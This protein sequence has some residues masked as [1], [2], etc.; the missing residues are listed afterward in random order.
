MTRLRTTVAS[1][2]VLPLALAGCGDDPQPKM[3]PPSASSP[4]TP[5]PSTST[6][7]AVE[8]TLP[9]EAEGK[10]EAAAE[11]FV[12]YYW[13]LANY[14]QSTGDAQTFSEVAL[15]SCTTCSRAASY[16]EKA[17]RKGGYLRGGA[18]TV[19]EVAV[20]RG[21]QGEGVRT[22]VA[23]VKLTSAPS[24]ERATST[25]SPIE[26]D[27]SKQAVVMSLLTSDSG[28]RV[29]SWETR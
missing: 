27:S 16:F 19:T 10:D 1:A 11:A 13:D 4:S 17:Y 6:D 22:F 2:L 9:P 29:A 24:T 5:T 7:P 25:S 14:V 21:A 8:P 26:H 18:Y 28:F 15:P 20:S 23:T 3:P 12:R